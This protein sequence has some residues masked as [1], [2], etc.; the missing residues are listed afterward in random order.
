M[1]QEYFSNCLF[2]AIKAKLKDWKNIRIIFQKPHHFLWY[3][4]KDKRIYDFYQ[5]CMFK[6]WYEMFWHKGYIYSWDYE[7]YKRW[8][9]SKKSR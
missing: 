2:E 6:H 5:S 4:A 9:N 8:I 3:N 7:A 1:K